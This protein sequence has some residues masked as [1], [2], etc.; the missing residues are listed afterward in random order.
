MK[1]S[2]KPSEP[3]L[4]LSL[5]DSGRYVSLYGER[6]DDP[7][8]GQEIMRFEIGEDGNT[9]VAYTLKLSVSALLPVEVDAHGHLQTR[10][11]A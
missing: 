6:D 2:T 5:S 9:I 1:V 10:M 3:T 4:V 11:K 8:T 7:D